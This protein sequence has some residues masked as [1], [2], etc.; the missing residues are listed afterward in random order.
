MEHPIRPD[1][2]ISF[3]LIGQMNDEMP[4]DGAFSVRQQ[5]LHLLPCCL[6]RRSQ[7]DQALRSDD[8]RCDQ[9]P[10]VDEQTDKL[11]SALVLCIS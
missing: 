10:D 1:W 9:T 7:S 6:D 11:E 5:H 2:A 8:M 3:H 4:H